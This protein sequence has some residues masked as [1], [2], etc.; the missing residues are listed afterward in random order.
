M[1]PTPAARIEVLLHGEESVEK[2][3]SKVLEPAS[4]SLLSGRGVGSRLF[5][6]NLCA[7]MAPVPVPGKTLPGLESYRLYQVARMEDGRTR[8]RLR[9]GFFTDENEAGMVLASV[10]EQFPTAFTTCLC[11]EDHRFA[12]GYTPA[13]TTRPAPPNRSVAIVPPAVDAAP[14]PKAAPTSPT[15]ERAPASKP[16]AAPAIA[17]QTPQTS[18]PAREAEVIELTWEPAPSKPASTPTQTSA[19]AAAKPAAE[20]ERRRE[21]A[22]KAEN[23]PKGASATPQGK[24]DEVRLPPSKST[25]ELTLETE[26]ARTAQAEDRRTDRTVTAGAKPS[27]TRQP[28]HVGK[29]AHIPDVKLD[30]ANDPKPAAAASKAPTAAKAA[31]V[32]V[33]AA[34]AKPVSAPPKAPMVAKPAAHAQKQAPATASAPP[35]TTRPAVTATSRGLEMQLPELDSTQTIRA[36]TSTELSDENQEKWF[37]IQ[38]AVS[39]QPVNLD[40]MPRLDIFEAYRLYSVATAGS[41]KIVHSLRLG[42]FREAV[43]AEAVS[44]YLNTFFGSPSVMRISVAEQ[45][46]FKDPPAHKMPAAGAKPESNVVALNAR[47]RNAPVVPTVTV[48]VTPRIDTSATGSFKPNATGSFKAN[49]SGSFKASSTGTHRAV[50]VASKPEVATPSGSAGKTAST[51]RF[52]AVR[53]PTLNEQLLQEAREVELSESAIRKLPKNNSLLARLVGKLTK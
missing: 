25:I 45:L 4:G 41:G 19:P 20:I 7:S 48:E 5:V 51:G 10:R 13:A 21:P 14:A 50:K 36:L 1:T 6:I 26:P 35:V 47:E 9:L 52:K 15:K 34:S 22:S 42:F 11:D 12:R 24:R 29:G 53:K 8:H 17:Q 2:N 38:L 28:F 32:S 39:D 16:Q 49:D 31:P 27:A 40:A 23:P 33:P 44:G 46:R 43:S 18:R 37:A 3:T 30:L